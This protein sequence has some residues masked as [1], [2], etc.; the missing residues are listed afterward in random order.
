MK[1]DY[2]KKEAIKI[3]EKS[4]R[5]ILL[6]KEGTCVEGTGV[7]IITLMMKALFEVEPIRVAVMEAVRIFMEEG[8]EHYGEKIKKMKATETDV[9]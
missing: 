1:K 4:D 2:N 9:N 3:F 8:V 6:C 7:E 5:Y